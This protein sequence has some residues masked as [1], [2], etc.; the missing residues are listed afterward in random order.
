MPAEA[1]RFYYDGKWFQMYE[2]VSKSGGTLPKMEDRFYILFSNKELK[3]GSEWNVYSISVSNF[4][5]SII[6]N[7]MH[8]IDD[9]LT[10]PHI[11]DIISIIC[12]ITIPPRVKSKKCIFYE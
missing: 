11:G 9:T 10:D 1:P 5:E 7:E 8:H 3:Q 6:L 2:W 12:K 4:G